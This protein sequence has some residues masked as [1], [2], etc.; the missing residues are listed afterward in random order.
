MVFRTLASLPSPPL[1]LRLPPEAAIVL[2]C[3]IVW[4]AFIMAGHYES[5]SNRVQ[6][7]APLALGVFAISL[8]RRSELRS[9][10]DAGMRAGAFV[11]S[12]VGGAAAALFVRPTLL[13]L[14][15]LIVEV[16]I[17]MALFGP[18]WAALVSPMVLVVRR[19]RREPSHDGPDAAVVVSMLWAFAISGV[20][21]LRAAAL[22]NAPGGLGAALAAIVALALAAAGQWVRRARARFLEDVRRGRARGWSI[23]P[24]SDYEARRGL[25]PAG[26]GVATDGVVVF[27][28]SRAASARDSRG[29]RSYREP[30]PAVAAV[31]AAD[32]CPQLWASVPLADDGGRSV[33]LLAHFRDHGV[34]RV[35][36]VV[37]GAIGVLLVVAPLFRGK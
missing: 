14:A 33:S 9:L 23:D 18:I 3:A 29:P 24:A 30:A 2:A 37:F 1:R 35:Q 20:V 26:V 25:I 16:G 5:P 27:E 31:R 6:F 36:L 28:P 22:G 11:G 21:A 19:A 8:V 17:I 32:A 10:V 13:G 15:A 4:S 34:P 7:G 12:V